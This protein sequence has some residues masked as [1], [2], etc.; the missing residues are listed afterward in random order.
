MNAMSQDLIKETQRQRLEEVIKVYLQQTDTQAKYWGGLLSSMKDFSFY[1]FRTHL[2][3]GERN[4]YQIQAR[5]KDPSTKAPTPTNW[6]IAEGRQSGR[7]EDV[8]DRQVYLTDGRITAPVLGIDTKYNR[9]LTEDG[10]VYE[11]HT[12]VEPVA[13]PKK[14]ALLYR[15]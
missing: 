11:L 5:E 6:Y 15:S 4:P 13:A 9:I 7:L 14:A 2:L 10:Q 8:L 3:L 12:R 1:Y